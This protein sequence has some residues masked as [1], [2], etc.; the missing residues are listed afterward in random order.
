MLNSITSRNYNSS[1]SA[2]GVEVHTEVE[3]SPSPRSL[4]RIAAASLP[5]AR[6]DALF[7]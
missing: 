7:R 4:V 1:G 3:V 5:A 6:C 2:L